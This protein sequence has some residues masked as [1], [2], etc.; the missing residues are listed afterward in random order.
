MKSIIFLEI[1][2]VLTTQEGTDEAMKRR[3]D[4]FD[5]N[6]IEYFC[7]KAVEALN[8]ITNATDAEFVIISNWRN[9]MSI[10]KMRKL[11]NKRQITGNILGY[12]PE[13]NINN[14]NNIKKWIEEHGI[15]KSFI[16]I[17][18]NKE[19]QEIYTEF[20]NNRC[21]GTEYISGIAMKSCYKRSINYL[22]KTQIN[23][24][25][26]TEKLF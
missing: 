16:I 2:G 13:T 6:G 21:I 19:I 4:I 26:K 14:A 25:S 23:N 17:D 12:A 18:D 9:K 5:E 10:D 11:F 24:Q 7:P 20:P 8:K 3:G 15:P 1:D 22:N